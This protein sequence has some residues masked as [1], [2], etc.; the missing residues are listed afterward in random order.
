MPSASDLIFVA[1]LMVLLL[2]PLA[3]KLLGDAGIGWHIR[4]GQQILST[5]AVPRTDPFSST[6][7]G[8]PWF[9]WEWLFDVVV[10]ELDHVAGL[11]GVTWLTA[12]V[13][14]GVFG[15][16]FRLL[17]RREM[18]VA[19]SLILML[20]ALC[21][22]TIHFLARPHVVSWLFTLAFF[23]VLDS[24]ERNYFKG[25][26]R[27]RKLW[28]LPP[29]MLIWVNVHGGFLLGFV[30]LGVFWFGSLWT[31]Y[32]TKGDGIDDVLHKI[33]AAKR[34]RDLTRVGLVSVIASLINPYGWNLHAH[35]ASYLSNRFLMDHIE[36]FQSPNFHGVAQKCF[37]ILLVFSLGVLVTRGRKLRTSEGLLV[38]FVT[39][40]G[41]YAAR[42]IPISSILLA[43]IIGPWMPS[44]GALERFG[45]RMSVIELE[46]RAHLWPIAATLVTLMIAI[47]GGRLGS[48]I[49]MDAHFGP[50][51]MPVEAAN[52][53]EA[54]QAQGSVLSPDYW[55]GYFIY[56]MYPAVRVVLDDR[57]DLYGAEFLESYLRMMH[58]E[59]GWEEFL[60]D[61]DP[62]Y[63]V[64]PRHAPLANILAKMPEWNQTYSDD[65]SV[66]FVH[67]P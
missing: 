64:M 65:V 6:M 43:M 29:L 17:I 10:G 21:S 63:V 33:A 9:A 19:Y 57:H 24:T 14:A 52:Y 27:H 37:L 30:L 41:L 48:N 31:W 15:W 61:H 51:R 36:E 4:T 7:E 16:M 56:R 45:L 1:I 50:N 20:V 42:N 26:G 39:Y 58:V 5:H 40:A 67:R 23:W 18:N 62:R 47:N 3:V 54:H 22:S 13:I 49:V 11:N 38:L 32:R 59:Q 8:K 25:V 28:A 55:G 12:V 60:R 2:T 35:I 34:V 53:L 44:Y 66:I 46:L